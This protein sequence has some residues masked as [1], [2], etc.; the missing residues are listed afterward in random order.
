[1]CRKYFGAMSTKNW[2]LQKLL[3]LEDLSMAYWEVEK[4]RVVGRIPGYAEDLLRKTG[5]IIH[6]MESILIRRRDNGLLADLKKD[7][8]S[9]LHC[10]KEARVMKTGLDGLDRKLEKAG[11]S[12]A[13]MILIL[14]KA[15]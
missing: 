9:F 11:K 10:M 13:G 1:V 14:E 7:H 6:D 8:D 4:L 3:T 12:V 15:Q 2:T 5:E